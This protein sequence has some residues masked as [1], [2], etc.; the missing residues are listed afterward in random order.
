[1][2]H[3]RQQREI[4]E[5]TTFVDMKNTLLSLNDGSIYQYK[6]M[7]AESVYSFI[8][9][10][11]VVVS[12]SG[13]HCLHYSDVRKIIGNELF[14]LMAIINPDFDSMIMDIEGKKVVSIKTLLY[15]I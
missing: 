7:L 5:I 14:A 4:G 13:Y 2:I 9:D 3:H 8:K 15:F 6:K 12:E 1:M 11:D 10:K